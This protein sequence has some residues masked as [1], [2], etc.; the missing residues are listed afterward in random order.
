MVDAFA[1]VHDPRVDRRR[2]HRLTEILV[3]AMLAIINGATAWSDMEAFATTRLSWLRTFLELP[4]RQPNLWVS[5][6][7][8]GRSPRLW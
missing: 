1:T 3:V 5:H 8:S 7:G 6:A 4:P 2:L